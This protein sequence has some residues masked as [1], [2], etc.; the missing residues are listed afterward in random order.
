MEAQKQTIEVNQQLRYFTLGNLQP[1]T[2]VI[3]MV[4]HGYGQ[5][6]PYFL[7][8]FQVL[9][10]AG[11]F[12]V[13]PEGISKFYLEGFSGRVGASW[14]TREDRQTDIDNYVNYLTQIY[15]TTLQGHPAR[16]N[17][18]GFSQ[19]VATISRWALL[20]E[21]D[22]Q[23]LILW[24]GVFPDDLPITASCSLLEGKKLSLIYGDNDPFITE[25]KKL[26]QI[27]HFQQFQLNPN[28]IR[29]QGAH[30]INQEVLK[31]YFIS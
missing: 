13:A 24:A 1:N 5:L 30:E 7:R 8:H 20:A 6:A 18:L 15:K 27:K 29:F 28:I 17:L 16:L 25:E 22:F 4:A 23:Q 21:P 11:H 31:N 3:W 10:D 26:G 14:M 2:P 19:G 12:I 9:A